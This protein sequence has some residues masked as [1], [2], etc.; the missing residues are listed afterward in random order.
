MSEKLKALVVHADPAE[1]GPVAKMLQDTNFDVEHAPHGPA[2]FAAM[3]RSRFDLIVTDIKLHRLD[4]FH[5][6]QAARD[7]NIP[8]KIIAFSG[9]LGRASARGVLDIAKRAGAHET[10]ERPHKPAH[11]WKLLRNMFPQKIL[12]RRKE[13]RN[14]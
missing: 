13:P 4:G 11:L 3:L 8:A 12:D 2:A 14:P 7:L 5:V 10:V 1:T 9:K 6:I